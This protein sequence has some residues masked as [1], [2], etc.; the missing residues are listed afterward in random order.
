MNRV[1]LMRRWI[2]AAYAVHPRPVIV[3]IGAVAEDISL[4]EAARPMAC[5]FALFEHA[6]PRCFFPPF[7]IRRASR[8]NA[9]QG[10]R[11]SRSITTL[12]HRFEQWTRLL[13]SGAMQAV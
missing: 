10:R 5:R 7:Y 3:S 4:S 1:E 8:L 12:A 13:S 6:S 11:R 2:G 9:G